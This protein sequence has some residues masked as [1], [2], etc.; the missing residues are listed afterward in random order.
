MLLREVL[1][2]IVLVDVVLVVAHV[3]IGHGRENDA[4]ALDPQLVR[5]GDRGTRRAFRALKV[6]SAA[7]F[8]VLVVFAAHVLRDGAEREAALLAA[9]VFATVLRSLSDC[10]SLLLDSHHVA[11]AAL[12]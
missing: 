11:G 2:A 4:G 9:A 6:L 1:D 10:V 8:L 7:R 12:S 5:R 3:V